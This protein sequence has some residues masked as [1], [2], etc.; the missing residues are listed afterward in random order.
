MV[1]GASRPAHPPRPALPRP[2]MQNVVSA[3]PQLN[4]EGASGVIEAKPQMRNLRSDITKFVPTNVR[5]RRDG[6]VGKRKQL[7]K[8]SEM[9]CCKG[10]YLKSITCL[11][12]LQEVFARPSPANNPPQV[13]KDDAYAQ[14]MK[15]MDQL[16]K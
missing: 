13:S 4:K 6:G 16:M 12:P 1:M 7:G 15:E 3:G 11:D 5:V 9:T 10:L 14:F 8:E 2:Q